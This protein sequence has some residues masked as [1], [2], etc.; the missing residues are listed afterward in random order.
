MR[1]NLAKLFLIT[2]FAITLPVVSGAAQAYYHHGYH[3]S[4]VSISIGSGSGYYYP[5]YYPTYS[6]RCKWVPAHWYNGYWY[7]ARTVCY[8]GIYHGKQCK[9][10]SGYWHHGKWHPR[11]RVCWYN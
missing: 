2:G 5:A 1:N 4:S 10:V 9:W 7:P 11:H 8:N 6:T 3:T